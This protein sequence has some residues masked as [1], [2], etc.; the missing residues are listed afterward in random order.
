MFLSDPKNHRILAAKQPAHTRLLQKI[1]YFLLTQR[2][3]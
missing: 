2:C 3:D 1:G